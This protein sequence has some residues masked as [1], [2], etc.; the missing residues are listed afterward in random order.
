MDSSLSASTSASDLGDYDTDT[1]RTK[2]RSSLG[3]EKKKCSFSTSVE[4]SFPQTGINK[5]LMT[6][7]RSLPVIV[8][9]QSEA[10][11]TIRKLPKIS[12]SHDRN[13]DTIHNYDCLSLERPPNIDFYRM[14]IQKAAR[15]SVAQ[16]LH[17]KESKTNLSTNDV[18]QRM[19]S[20]DSRRDVEMEAGIEP[21]NLRTQKPKEK[22]L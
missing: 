9:D 12:I 3:S 21:L 19:P 20:N 22:P 18:K 2:S 1:T 16:L 10:E 5:D 17:G 8:E 14:T 13:L 6:R 4:D 15:P 7:H 11:E